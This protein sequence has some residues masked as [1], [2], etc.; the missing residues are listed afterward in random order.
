[1]AHTAGLLVG[2]GYAQLK[3]EEFP[4]TEALKQCLDTPSRSLLQ[5]KEGLARS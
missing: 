3:G 2:T 1:M 5:C 4:A